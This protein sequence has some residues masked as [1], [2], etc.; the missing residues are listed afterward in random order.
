MNNL[1]L[2]DLNIEDFD[3]INRFYNMRRTETADSNVLDLFLWNDCYP[4][5]ILYTE[6]GIMIIGEEEG[7]YYSMIPFCKK[8]I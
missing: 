8:K 6:K 1:Q 7:K 4:S 2:K 5:K 3:T